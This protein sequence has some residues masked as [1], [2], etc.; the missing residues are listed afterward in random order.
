MKR[1]YTIILSI[2]LL[3]LHLSTIQSCY[4]IDDEELNAK[5]TSDCSTIHGKFTTENGLPVKD[6]S[7]EF[8]WSSPSHMGATAGFG[9][10][11]RKIATTKTDNNGEYKIV[12]HSKD[13]ELISGNYAVQFK[14]KDNPYFIETNYSYF[15]I[16]GVDRRDTVI[17]K[18]YHLPKKGATI[19]IKIKNPNDILG[20]DRLICT[21]AHKFGDLSAQRVAGQLFSFIADEATFETAVNQPTYIR[22]AKRKNGEYVNSYDSVIISHEQTLLYEIEF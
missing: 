21:I 6:V 8:D 19:K 9:G 5:C 12:F 2:F 22:I 20:D 1:A 17:T 13:E 18:N 15:K 4:I 3:T 16:Y 10:R 11:I 7:I 14:V